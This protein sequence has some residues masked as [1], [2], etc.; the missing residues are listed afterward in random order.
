MFSL[1]Q[2]VSQLTRLEDETLR[3]VGEEVRALD[4]S[5]SNSYSKHAAGWQTLSLFDPTDAPGGGDRFEHSPLASMPRTRAAL[6]GLGL[7]YVAAGLAKLEANGL[8][9]ERHEQQ[10]SSPGG[11]LR[12]HLPVDTNAATG[13][14]IERLKIF[15]APGYVWKLNPVFQLAASNLGTEAHIHLVLNCRDDD[16]RLTAMLKDETLDEDFVECLPS[17]TRAELDAAVKAAERLARRGDFRLAEH[18]LLRLQHVY[19][20]KEG[21]PQELVARMYASLGDG[22]RGGVQANDAT[23]P[24]DSA[25][26]AGAR[27]T[28]DTPSLTL[29][30]KPSQ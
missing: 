21:A 2:Q 22:E 29:L 10:K 17:P 16:E 24:P 25:G 8:V 6:D 15:L 1:I 20:L 19:Y 26:G 23:P 14:V 28:G 12:L 9:L 7:R 18:S 13:V 11:R 30:K 3:A 27:N 5:M 4:K